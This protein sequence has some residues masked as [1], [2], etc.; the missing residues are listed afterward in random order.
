VWLGVRMLAAS[1]LAIYTSHNFFLVI[2]TREAQPARRGDPAS[3]MKLGSAAAVTL[4][5]MSSNHTKA[6][7]LVERFR[8]VESVDLV[9]LG[10]DRVL[11]LDVAFRHGAALSQCL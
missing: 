2:A 5:M 8:D 7:S 1:L 10:H 3:P 6:Y 9:G 4:G 11:G